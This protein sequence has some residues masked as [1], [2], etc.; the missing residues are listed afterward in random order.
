MWTLFEHKKTYKYI[1][2]RFRYITILIKSLY[3]SYEIYFFYKYV[4]PLVL[5]DHK[6]VTINAIDCGF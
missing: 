2:T 6:C 4:R 3:I 1:V 5:Q